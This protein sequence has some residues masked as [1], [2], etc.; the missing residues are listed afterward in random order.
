M[1]SSVPPDIH[2]QYIKLAIQHK[3]PA[4]VEASVVLGDLEVLDAAAKEAIVFIAPSCTM[5]YHQSISDLKSIIDSGKYGKI[6][7]FSNHVGQYLPDWHPWEKVSDYYVSQKETGGGRE[8]VPFELTW[9]VDLIGFPT[10]IN[11]YYG[12]TMDVG[13]DID[14]TY[15]ICMV[16]DN[17]IGTLTVDVVSRFA[18][19]SLILNFE[20]GQ[21]LWDWNNHQ[22]KVYDAIDKR[23]IV[24]KNPQGTSVHGYNVNIVDDTYIDEL[25]AFI[26]CVKGVGKYPNTLSK[27]IKVLKLLLEVEKSQE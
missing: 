24:Y 3:I 18:T 27:D 8:I 4:F 20:N 15:S 19:R 14:D 21:A 1:Q 2:N 12:K 13:A 10:H 17:C 22:L 7:N 6:T 16:F 23:W 9:I 11:G 26:N 25:N 5:L